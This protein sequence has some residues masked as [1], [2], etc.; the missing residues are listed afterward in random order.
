MAVSE[1]TTVGAR[2][3]QVGGRPPEGLAA[4]SRAEGRMAWLDAAKGM[5]I[6][7][8]VAFHVSIVIKAAAASGMPLALD[9][10]ASRLALAASGLGTQGVTVFV[11][12][13]GFALTWSALCRGGL[14]VPARMYPGWVVA[15]LWRLMVMYWL[16]NAMFLAGYII[17]DKPGPGPGLGLWIASAFGVHAWKAE[18]FGGVRGAWWFVGLMIQLTL[19]WPL[20][21]RLLKRLGPGWFMAAAW[22]I[23]VASRFVCVEY[24]Y[25]WNRFLEYGVFSGCRVFEF[26]IGMATAEYMFSRRSSLSPCGALALAVLAAVG[27]A[28]GLMM[29]KWTGAYVISPTIMS[30]CICILAAMAAMGAS[31]IRGLS[32]SLVWLGKFTLPIFLVHAVGASKQLAL[33][34][35]LGLHNGIAVLSLLVVISIIEGLAFYVLTA[36]FIAGAGRVAGRFRRTAR[37]PV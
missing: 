1:M 30:A 26:A 5:A 7:W 13:S 10:W 24:L 2:Q 29:K 8:I 22:L 34:I 37:A 11:A 3:G 14:A 35:G 27:Y 12:A 36:A 28:D 6:L 15:R 25:D 19:M 31:R 32:S 16:A 18:W 4:D 9:G 23:T 17:L 20:L 33:L 21:A